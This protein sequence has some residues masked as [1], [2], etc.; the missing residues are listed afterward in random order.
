MDI[1]ASVQA[2]TELPSSAA[3]Q[4]RPLKNI[5]SDSASTNSASF[6]ILVAIVPLLQILPPLSKLSFLGVFLALRPSLIFVINL[7]QMLESERPSAK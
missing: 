5:K 6:L 1:K 4:R 7:L 3:I 2:Q